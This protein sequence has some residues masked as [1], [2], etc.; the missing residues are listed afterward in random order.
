MKKSIL[1]IDDDEDELKIFTEALND[2]NGQF[3]CVLVQ[4]AEAADALLKNF[5]PDYI[6][7]DLN[8]PRIDGLACL[9]KIRQQVPIK[10]TPVFIYSNCIT[11]DTHKEAS[12]LGAAGCIQKPDSINSLGALL[13]KLLSPIAT[14]R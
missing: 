3:E 8:L 4:S 5:T 2:L 6:F 9:A 10:H 7:L 14:S 1:L 13:Q 11:H 12:V